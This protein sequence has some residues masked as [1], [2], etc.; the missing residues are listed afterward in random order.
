MTISNPNCFH[1]ITGNELEARIEI[2]IGLIADYGSIEGEPHKIW[3][4]DQILR[5][6]TGCPI[7]GE[8]DEYRQLNWFKKRCLPK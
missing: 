8:N 1:K 2:A 6:L 7:E 4:I 3:L 5:T